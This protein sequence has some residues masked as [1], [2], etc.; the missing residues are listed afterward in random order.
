M[1]RTCA[2]CVSSLFAVLLP[3][4]PL[5]GEDSLTTQWEAHGFSIESR[6][7]L[8]D[9]LH[10][11][12]ENGSVPGGVVILVH[13]GDVIFRESFGFRDLKYK[14]PF[15]LATPF[16]AASLSKSIIS[17][18]VVKLHSEGLLDL[19]EAMDLKLPAAKQL[20]VKGA[21]QLTRMPTVRE[22]LHHTAGFA[23]D[24]SQFGRPWLQFRGQGMTLAEAVDAELKIPMTR[25]PGERFAYSGIGYHIVGRIIEVATGRRIEDVLQTQLCKPLGMQTTTFHP[26][27]TRTGELAG[28]YWRWRSDGRFRHQ[29][30][31]RV[32]PFGEYASVGGGIVTT[33]DDL[34]RFISLPIPV[35]RSHRCRCISRRLMRCI[36]PRSRFLAVT[37]IILIKSNRRCWKP[38]SGGWIAK[39]SM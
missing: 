18:L 8:Y 27:Q 33:A 30:D 21:D 20:D 11:S 16:H 3:V 5:F 39:S 25:Q 2:I 1:N 29:L 35:S 34:T 28:F 22:C 23:A 4:S 13:R 24:E 9:C 19:D 14:R 36:P 26:E 15:E 10:D 32:V 31:P 17:K 7:K 38:T 6:N 12:V 37:I